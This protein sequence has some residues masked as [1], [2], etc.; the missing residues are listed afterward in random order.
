MTELAGFSGKEVIK[1]LERFGYR[2]IRQRG[3]RV[4]L[5]HR[6]GMHFRPLVIPPHKEL[7]VGLL[8]Q[9]LKDAGLE[10]SAF[11]DL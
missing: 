9:I 11:L 4:R 3:S 10:P 6:D 8:R 5:K 7:K 2:T 1:R